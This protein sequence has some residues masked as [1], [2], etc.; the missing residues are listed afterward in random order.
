MLHS[1]K[2]TAQ[3]VLNVIMLGIALSTA[4]QS[5]P[6]SLADQ[7]TDSLIA[8]HKVIYMDGTPKLTKAHQDSIRELITNFYYDQFRHFSDPAAPYFM[9]MSRDA[10]LAMGIG[11][12]VRMRGYYDWDGAMPSP[13]FAPYLIPMQPDPTNMRHFATTPSGSSLFFR[14]IGRNKSLGSYQLYIEANFNGYGNRDFHLKKA[15][16]IVNDFTIGYASSTFSDPAAVPATVDAQGP[17]NK[18]SGT[19]VLVRYMPTFGKR[20]TAAVS[21]ET[22][23][24]QIGA[25]NV[26]TATI[27]DRLPDLAAFIQYAWGASQHVRLAGICRSLGYRDLVKGQEANHSITGWGMQLSSVA[28]PVAPVTTYLTVN[29]GHGIAGAGGDL[30][31]GNYDLVSDPERPG[32]MYA[33]ATLGWCVGVQYNFRPNLFASV[34]MSESRYLPKHDVAGSEYKYGLFGAVN[35]FWNL[36]PRIQAGA[37]L[38]LGKRKNFDGDSRNAK[39]VGLMAQFSF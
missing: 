16:A 17:N 30:Q 13:G 29:Y 7:Q 8:S 11:G 36:T 28:H 39:R 21:A 2:T 4:A 15:Y 38:D 6:K 25:D 20:W 27:S 12:C 26:N 33:P 10:S 3:T 37:E 24:T 23:S 9:F 22:P 18:I 19:N 1:F 34:S 31:I 35:V 14:V 32:R 5:E